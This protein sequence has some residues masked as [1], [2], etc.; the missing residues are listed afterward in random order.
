MTA[1][2]RKA[3]LDKGFFAG[4]DMWCK[5]ATAAAKDPKLKTD[6]QRRMAVAISMANVPQGKRYARV[7]AEARGRGR[8]DWSCPAI[9]VDDARA[10]GATAQPEQGE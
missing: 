1:A 2:E 7:E 9:K 4:L 10:A 3:A 8:A 5:A 6:E